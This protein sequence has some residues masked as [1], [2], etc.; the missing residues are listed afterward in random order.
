MLDIKRNKLSQAPT[1]DY[2][3][4]SLYA[5]DKDQKISLAYID[6]AYKKTKICYELENMLYEKAINSPLRIFSHHVHWRRNSWKYTPPLKL[7][8]YCVVVDIAAESNGLLVYILL[9]CHENCLPH[10]AVNVPNVENV[11]KGKWFFSI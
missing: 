6:L 2:K 9:T 4:T 5:R 1:F 3:R 8:L 7:F 11:V 10:N